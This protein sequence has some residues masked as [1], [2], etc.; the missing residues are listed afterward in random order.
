M[1]NRSFFRHRLRMSVSYPEA[2]MIVP[3]CSRF[4]FLLRLNRPHEP[5]SR[6]PARPSPGE[7]EAGGQ[8][9]GISKREGPP[10]AEKRAAK[11]GERSNFPSFNVLHLS[12]LLI[13]T[14][15]KGSVVCCI[16]SARRMVRDENRPNKIILLS[17]VASRGVTGLC[18]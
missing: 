1:S 3:M 16:V 18:I 11:R 13:F 14:S 9:S 12:I 2:V 5:S 4:G 7:V 15:S 17:R 8:G 6:P 10:R